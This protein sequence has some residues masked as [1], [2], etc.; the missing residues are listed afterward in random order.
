MRLLLACAN[1]FRVGLVASSVVLA[2][3]SLAASLDG[4]SGG[5][6]SDAGTAPDAPVDGFMGDG[7]ALPPDSADGS[8]A[9]SSAPIK[10]VQQLGSTANASVSF[11]KPTTAGTLLVAMRPDSAPLSGAGW[12]AV[13][14]SNGADTVF[15]WS[16]NPGGL[17]TFAVPSGGNADVLLLEV[18]GAPSPF[19]VGAKSDTGGKAGSV[20]AL[21][22]SLTAPAGA[23]VLLY[24]D[25][26][27]STSASTP[28]GW[29][30]L[31]TDGNNNFAWW[32]TADGTAPTGM[33]TFAPASAAALMVL[34]LTPK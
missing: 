27:S 5:V 2:S 1:K 3:C 7:A 25:T 23:L 13:T 21:T 34:A 4:L 33:V 16:D 20:S 11:A 18:S 10:I 19:L 9:D 6:R 14:S 24:L 8:A 26:N 28:S 17:Q 31:G 12:V 22:A 15:L 29:A 30:A 32:R